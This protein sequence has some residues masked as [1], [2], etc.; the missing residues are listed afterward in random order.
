[1]TPM[2]PYGETCN[3][4]DIVSV[5]VDRKAPMT[6]PVVIRVIE[7]EAIIEIVDGEPRDLSRLRVHAPSETHTYV[8][9]IDDIEYI[10]GIIYLVV[11]DHIEEPV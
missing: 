6:A 10:D 9:D 2:T 1:M 4:D 11:G 8:L 3:L 7:R 5:A